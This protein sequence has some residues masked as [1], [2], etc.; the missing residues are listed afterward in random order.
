M[1]KNIIGKARFKCLLNVNDI[2]KCVNKQSKL[3]FERF[4]KDQ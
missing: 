4:T 3:H 2:N 1:V